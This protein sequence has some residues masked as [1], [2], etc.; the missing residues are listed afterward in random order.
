MIRPIK[1]AAGSLNDDAKSLGSFEEVRNLAWG[2][3][4]DDWKS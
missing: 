1:S 4:A 3:I 2:K